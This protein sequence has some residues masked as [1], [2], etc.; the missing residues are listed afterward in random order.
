MTRFIH[1]EFAKDYLEEL[2]SPLGKVKTSRKVSGEIKEVDVWFVPA[3]RGNT[4]NV[5]MSHLSKNPN[6]GTTMFTGVNLTLSTNPPTHIFSLHST[7]LRNPVSPRY[8]VSVAFR[9]ILEC[10]A[11]PPI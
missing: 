5:S 8:R 9:M 3:R 11:R 7:G 1:D 10:Y 4:Q 6:R 2:L